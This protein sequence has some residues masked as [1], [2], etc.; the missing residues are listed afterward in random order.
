MPLKKYGVLKGTALG[1]LRDADDDHYQIL[2][3]AGAT[4]RIIVRL[5]RQLT[6]QDY[7]NL[8][9]NQPIPVLTGLPVTLPREG[10]IE[11]ELEQKC[12]SIQSLQGSPGAYRSAG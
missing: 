2:I 3:K 10:A 4:I 12:S 1:H 8:N 11:I 7:M 9:L 6:E 5:H